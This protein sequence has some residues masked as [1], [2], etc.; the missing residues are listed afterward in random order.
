MMWFHHTSSYTSGH[1]E[2]TIFPHL[3]ISL[4]NFH[5]GTMIKATFPSG[6][7]VLVVNDVRLLLLDSFVALALNHTTWPK[8]AVVLGYK[9]E[10]G[11]ACRHSRAAAC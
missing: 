7:K 4:D 9:V 1:G 2:T 5:R 11:N 10:V 8:D 6:G 3:Q